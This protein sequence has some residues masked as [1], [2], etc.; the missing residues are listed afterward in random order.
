MN[1]EKVK[2][3]KK[4]GSLLLDCGNLEKGITILTHK[5]KELLE[6]ERVSIF[7]YTQSAN[8]VWTYLADGVEKLVLPADKGVVGY[9]VKN[10]T[11]K[12][13]NDTSKEPLFYR[14]VDKITGYH[15]KN[16][17]AVPLLNSEGDL[18]GVVQL[19]NKSS[20][21]TRDDINI[22]YLF[23]KYISPPLEILLSEQ[24]RSLKIEE[25]GDII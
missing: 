12:K 10:K 25:D 21:F 22:A 13:V 7:I 19:L 4:I 3:L 14:E 8:M 23:S 15:T 16:I 1:I 5:L 20:R 18:L 6:V 11:I 2:E 24:S 17:L 9:V